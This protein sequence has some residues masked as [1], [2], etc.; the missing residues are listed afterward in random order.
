MTPN[1][2]IQSRSLPSLFLWLTVTHFVVR[3]VTANVDTSS[4]SFAIFRTPNTITIVPPYPARHVQIVLT[5]FRT[6]EELMLMCFLDCTAVVYDGTNAHALPRTRRAYNTRTNFIEPTALP[7]LTNRAV[8]YCQRGFSVSVLGTC[9]H[10]PRCD[11]LVS[12]QTLESV[13]A[14]SL[15]PLIHDV[16]LEYTRC[17]YAFSMGWLTSITNRTLDTMTKES[18]ETGL[19]TMKQTAYSSMDAHIPYLPTLPDIMGRISITNLNT[20]IAARAVRPPPLRPTLFIPPTLTLFTYLQAG[21]PLEA[22]PKPIIQAKVLSD[23]FPVVSPK[24][25]EFGP[26]DYV[27][28]AAASREAKLSF[29]HPPVLRFSILDTIVTNRGYLF[30]DKCPKCSNFFLHSYNVDDP[31]RNFCVLPTS[32]EPTYVSLILSSSASL[33]HRFLRISPSPCP[34]CTASL[35]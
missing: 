21:A 6:I 14:P 25:L 8:K 31:P 29:A 34:S 17:C 24:I 3:Q 35:K 9:H 13:L 28:F 7:E 15:S 1:A 4:P 22:I 5:V 2:S 18:T 11:I 16:L 26:V 30:N 23:L 10:T 19:K 33:T 20:A 27:E 12:P 32:T